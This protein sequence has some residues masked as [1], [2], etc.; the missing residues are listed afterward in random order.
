M[1]RPAIAWLCLAAAACGSSADDADLGQTPRDAVT[2]DREDTDTGVDE[3]DTGD[4]ALEP[5]YWSLQGSVVVQDGLPR[6]ED[7]A[8]RITFHDGA[9]S[10]WSPEDSD[11]SG[12]T[13][14]PTLAE[15]ADDGLI[16]DTA[17]IA[18][19]RIAAESSD[20]EA[21]P[22][23]VPRPRAG[24]G[25][26]EVE[27][28]LG[29]GSQDARLGGFM[30]AA[31]LDPDLPLYGAY[32]LQPSAR[33]DLLFSFGVGGTQAHFSGADTVVDGPPLPDGV[34]DLR[35]VALLPLP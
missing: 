34:Y 27:L 24:D 23:E 15:A 14:V 18:W 22:W 19:W 2:D 31:G 29:L 9:G 16:E 21:C 3:D 28:L 8:L 7:G 4:A 10:P 13:V 30:D 6:V 20:E 12:C 5:T 11:V 35:T 26:A 17:L 32:I 25:D 33:G 1:L